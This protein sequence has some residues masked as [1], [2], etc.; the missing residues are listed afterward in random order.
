M[1]ACTAQISTRFILISNS[2]IAAQILMKEIIFKE[3]LGNCPPCIL[4]PVV[5]TI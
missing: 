2:D 5:P 1:H 3:Y 4:K